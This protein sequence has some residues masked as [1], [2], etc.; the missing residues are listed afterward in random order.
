MADA[1]GRGYL[2]ALKDEFGDLL[3]QVVYQGTVSGGSRRVRLIT[4]KIIRRHPHVFEDA[5]H[6]DGFLTSGTWERASRPR[7][8]RCVAARLATRGLCSTMCRSAPSRAH[9]RNEAAIACGQG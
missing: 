3:P 6:R 5:S 1:I 7:R 9:Q 2:D 4:A 8:R